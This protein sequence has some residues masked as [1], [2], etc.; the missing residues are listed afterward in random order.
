MRSISAPPI[1]IVVACLLVACG[2]TTLYTVESGGHLRKITSNRAEIFQHK[3]IRETEFEAR[4][5]APPI[6][7]RT[8]HD[9]WTRVVAHWI[10]ANEFGTHQQVMAYIAEQRRA[11]GLPSL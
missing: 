1:V 9:Y 10:G 8:W 5:M 4:G 11:R 7:N 3:V 6:G 2:G